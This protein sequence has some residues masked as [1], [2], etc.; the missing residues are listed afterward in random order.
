MR[1]RRRDL[2]QRCPD[3]AERAAERLPL[4][5]LPRPTVAGGYVRHGAEIDPSAVLAQLRAAGARIAL[6][7]TVAPDAPLVFRAALPSDEHVPDAVGIHAP[8]P[9]AE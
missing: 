3:A 2:A 4:D 8:P 5:R 7:V 6:P 9:H 1:A